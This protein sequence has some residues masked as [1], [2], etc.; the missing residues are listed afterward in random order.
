[1]AWD[2]MI[3]KRH[4]ICACTLNVLLDDF[5]RTLLLHHTRMAD[6]QVNGRVPSLGCAWPEQTEQPLRQ[7][8][9]ARDTFRSRLGLVK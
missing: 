1:M 3:N 8:I 4:H 6:S 2:S 5:R 7:S 9:G